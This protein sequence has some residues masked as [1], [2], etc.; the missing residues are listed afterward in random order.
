ML[1]VGLFLMGVLTQGASGGRIEGTVTA[2]E[3]GQPIAGASVEVETLGRPA[4][5]DAQGHYRIDAVPAGERVLLV[6]RL[7]ESRSGATL[8]WLRT[9]C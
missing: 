4:V 3:T 1:R 6:R 8:R 7:V 5:T 2:A 9:E